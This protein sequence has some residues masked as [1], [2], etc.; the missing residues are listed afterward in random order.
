MRSLGRILCLLGGAGLGACASGDPRPDYERA[1]DAVRAVTG[2]QEVHDPGTPVLSELDLDGLLADGLGLREAT[3]L[4]LLEN[5]RLQAGFLELGVARADYVQAGLLQNPSLGLAFLLPEGGGRVKWTADLL[6]NVSDLWQLSSRQALAQAGVEQRVLELSR[7]AGGLVAATRRAY[8]EGVAAREGREL[9]RA[10]LELTRRALE[11]VRRQVELG[12]ATAT[13]AAL[14]ESASLA[15]DL[16]LRRAEREEVVALREL[17][18]LLS[19]QRDLLGV[20]LTDPLP[21]PVAP[22]LER[23]QVVA[24]ATAARPD[25]RAADSAVAAARERLELE[26]RRRRPDVSVGA[27]AER[28]E[29]GASTDFFLGPAAALELPL[30]DQNQAQIARAELELAARLKEREALQAEVRQEVRAAHDRAVVVAGA[31]AFAIDELVPQAER[32]AALAARA[33]ELGDATVLTLLQAQRHTLE[34]HRTRVAALLESA[35]ASSELERAAG[36]PLA[37]P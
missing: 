7:F 11:G 25:L 27:S 31:T 29:G 3:R 12:L 13:D 16:A 28:P 14:A 35:L 36:A 4:A 10:D 8:W 33:Y 20:V 26:Q 24:A 19:L 5:R 1:R 22:R 2:E 37:G 6:A 32:S 17:A 15:A 34:A 30:F 18:G 23:E 9:A 21:E